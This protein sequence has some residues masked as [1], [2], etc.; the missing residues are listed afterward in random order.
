MTPR[1]HSRVMT[2]YKFVASPPG[3]AVE[4]SRTWEALYL[5]TIPIVKD[6]VAI[7]YFASLG[8]P[9]FVVKDWRELENYTEEKLAATYEEYLKKANWEALH[10]DFW[11]A[12][13]KAEQ[14]KIRT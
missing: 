7:R 1:R 6:S 4:S 3:H 9:L 13:V 11:I 14:Q 10:M 2:T 12:K 8:L 5:R